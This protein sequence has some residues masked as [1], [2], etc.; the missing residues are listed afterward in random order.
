[1]SGRIVTRP[2]AD[3][4]LDDC[5]GYIAVDSLESAQRFLKAAETAFDS[6]SQMPEMGSPR[7]VRNPALVGL[8]SWPVPG[9]RNYLIFY[10]P[11]E[12]GIEVIRVLH[13]AR[14]IPRL[15]EEDVEGS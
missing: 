1:V 7:E 5:F 2:S 8:R 13:G 14:D 12:D 6:L 10:L 11:I 15:L 4:D 9:F 3:Q